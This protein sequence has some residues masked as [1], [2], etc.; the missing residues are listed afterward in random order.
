MNGNLLRVI[1]LY[2]DRTG[3]A[4]STFGRCA[5]GDSRL[6]RDMRDGR[7]LRPKTARRVREYMGVAL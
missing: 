4:E 2:C 1:R 7:E 5:I 3:T 6:V